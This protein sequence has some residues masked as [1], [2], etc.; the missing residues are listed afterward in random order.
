MNHVKFYRSGFVQRYHQNPEMSPFGQ[1]NAAHQWGVC[2]LLLI[3]FPDVSRSLLI[4]ALTHDV[5]EI[6]AGDLANP[7]K[8]RNPDLA[9]MH[10]DFESGCRFNIIGEPLFDQTVP[11]HDEAERLWLCDKL[12]AVLFTATFRP[13]LICKRGWPEQIEQLKHMSSK[14]GCRKSLEALLKGVLD[15]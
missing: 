3:L 2:A 13:E 9:N 15:D 8:E 5:G 4:A 10:R 12:E 7:T 1:N 11:F 14:L 6:D